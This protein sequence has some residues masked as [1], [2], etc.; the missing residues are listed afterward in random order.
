M[1]L[2]G[3]RQIITNLGQACARWDPFIFY[4]QTFTA[5]VESFPIG[6]DDIKGTEYS[7]EKFIGV[8]MYICHLPAG[9]FWVLP[10]YELNMG[11]KTHFQKVIKKEVQQSIM[12]FRQVGTYYR[13]RNRFCILTR[14]VYNA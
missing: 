5:M 7:L 12:F 8:C 9:R 14:A 3:G 2:P 10:A 13:T 4:T 11:G 6:Y 1:R